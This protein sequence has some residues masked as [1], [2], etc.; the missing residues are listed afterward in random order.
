M[1]RFKILDVKHIKA[2]EKG[3][4]SVYNKLLN[5]FIT[6][7][8]PEICT[9]CIVVIANPI[10]LEILEDNGI[11]GFISMKENI[12]TCYFLKPFTEEEYNDFRIIAKEDDYWVPFFPE[13]KQ[14][15][16][17][18]NGYIISFYKDISF[19]NNWEPVSHALYVQRMCAEHQDEL[20]YMDIDVDRYVEVKDENNSDYESKDVTDNFDVYAE[21]FFGEFEDNECKN[22]IW[23]CLKLLQKEMLYTVSITIRECECFKDNT[24]EVFGSDVE[25]ALNIAF[26]A[27]VDTEKRDIDSS[28]VISY[29]IYHDDELI[30]H[31]GF[32]R[33][34]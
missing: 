6:L 3:R 34:Q 27:I 22:E 13:Q 30:M 26:Q 8:Y 21:E 2:N 9:D 33:K 17:C 23:D 16:Y 14:I 5:K 19:N 18:E 20:D 7:P 32:W 11:V 25:D 15:N 4:I 10:D 31:N 24:R 29:R 12:R 1:K 28:A